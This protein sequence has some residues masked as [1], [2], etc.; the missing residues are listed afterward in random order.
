[1]ASRVLERF[2]SERLPPDQL[3]WTTLEEYKNVRLEFD[4]IIERTV[5]SI[6]TSEYPTIIVVEG[7]RGRFEY[8]I[9]RIS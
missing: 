5:K 2:P 6:P 4:D 3:Y 9:W 1:M 8:I 7:R